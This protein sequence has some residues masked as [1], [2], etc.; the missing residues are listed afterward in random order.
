M[1]VILR[2]VLKLFVPSEERLQGSPGRP[3]GSVWM[4]LCL[5][6]WLPVFRVGA[7]AAPAG[8]LSNA[9]TPAR[10]VVPLAPVSPVPLTALKCLFTVFPPY[11][12]SSLSSEASLFSQ[13][14][15]RGSV[16]AGVL[17]MLVEQINGD[18]SVHQ[19]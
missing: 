15:T 11:T 1:T 7:A 16:L 19:N 10:V 3:P 6:G 17:E 8:S 18:G 4:R 5:A 2:P 12:V 9:S 13:S 14:M